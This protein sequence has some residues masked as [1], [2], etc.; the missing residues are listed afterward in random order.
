MQGGAHRRLVDD[1]LDDRLRMLGDGATMRSTRFSV[2][3]KVSKA[4]PISMKK[5]RS[6][7]S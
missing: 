6:R 4:S 3:N 2:C 1:D 5:P 7:R